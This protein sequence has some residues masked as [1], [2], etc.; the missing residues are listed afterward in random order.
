MP[1]LQLERK[2]LWEAQGW[3]QARN[4]HT[5]THYQ[6]KTNQ[7][8]SSALTSEALQF[9]RKKKK[10]KEEETWKSSKKFP[11]DCISSKKWSEYAKVT[12]MVSEVWRFSL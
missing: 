3:G 8:K 4:P 5:D 2:V 7:I 10:K 12:E 11:Q 6:N 1:T 9:C